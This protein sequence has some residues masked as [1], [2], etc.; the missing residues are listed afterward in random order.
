[1]MKKITVVFCSLAMM[2]ASFTPNVIFKGNNGISL[3]VKVNAEEISENTLP[4]P[5]GLSHNPSA[6]GSHPY[7]FSWA[8]V[9]DADGYNVYKDGKYVATTTSA[10]YNFDKSEFTTTGEYQIS[11]AAIGTFGEGA[12]ASIIFTVSDETTS[13]N[14]ST[15]PPI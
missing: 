14:V 4:A 5:E 8:E 2:T 7:Y 6:D 3:T 11:V 15:E 1:M 10:G 13:E 9:E 12:K